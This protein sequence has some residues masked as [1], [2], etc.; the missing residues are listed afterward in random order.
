MPMHYDPLSSTDYL[1]VTGKDSAID[2]RGIRYRIERREEIEVHPFFFMLL[3]PVFIWLLV[4]LTGCTD[5]PQPQF[6]EA[7]ASRPAQLQ[8]S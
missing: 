8:A 4:L 7:N 1:R 6:I 5:N 2:G 3:T